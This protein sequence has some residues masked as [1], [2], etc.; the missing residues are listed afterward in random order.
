[1]SR[2]LGFVG[3]ISL[4]L[5]SMVGLSKEQ[6]RKF[7]STYAQVHEIWVKDLAKLN[8]SQFHNS[9]FYS[10]QNSQEYIKLLH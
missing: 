2:F 8:F 1:M 5:S 7:I 9:Q 4:K 6:D 3:S 10:Q